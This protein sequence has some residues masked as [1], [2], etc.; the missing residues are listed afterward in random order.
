MKMPWWSPY[1]SLRLLRTRHSRL[2]G[3]PPVKKAAAEHDGA[4]RHAD[5]EAHQ[6]G[7]VESRRPVILAPMTAVTDLPFRGR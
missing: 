6:D 3:A 7:P 1:G 4:K 5:S 2:R